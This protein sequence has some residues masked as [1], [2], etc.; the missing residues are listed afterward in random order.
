[1]INISDLGASLHEVLTLIH[2][3]KPTYPQIDLHYD[4]TN[5]LTTPV[6]VS[7]PQNGFRLRFDGADQR[8][9]LIEITDFTKIRLTYKG[10]ELVKNPQLEAGPAFKRIYQLFGASYPGEYHAPRNGDR[11][12]RYV[13]SWAGVA[14]TF[15]LLQEAWS[16]QK[17]HVSMLGSSAAAPA[18]TMA[19]FEGN[20]WPEVRNQLFVRLPSGPR[21]SAVASRPKDN[22]P[23]EIEVANICSMDGRIDL[24]RRDPAV[25][26]TIILNQTTPQDLITELGPPDTTHKRETDLATTTEQPLHKRASSMSNSRAHAHAEGR[27]SQ[28]SSY[29]ST[30]TDTFD[31]DFDSGDA[32]E[33]PTDRSSRETFWCYFSHGMDILIGPPSEDASSMPPLD[34]GDGAWV[35]PLAASPHLVVTKV[36]IHGNVPGSYAFNRHRRL[37]WILTFPNTEYLEA[38][39]DSETKFEDLKSTLLHIFHGADGQGVSEQMGKGK[40][41]NRTWGSSGGGGVG[42]TG[43]SESGFFLPDAE[44]ELV[45]G[46]GSEAWLGNTRVFAFPRLGFEVLES[47][48]VVGVTVS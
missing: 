15:P 5:P 13:L 20:S 39:L 3:D 9:R 14:F 41:V 19:V 23:I 30:G 21:L 6:I 26:L 40:V 35:T 36:I 16:P 32:D 17:D 31:A 11:Y 28:P 44:T 43:M 7:L 22:I 18:T 46:N 4:R 1:L 33:D 25:P 27:G 8:L 38:P 47:G 24:I 10:S 42:G 29:S 37:R 48:S 34:D 2:N 12:G 45:E